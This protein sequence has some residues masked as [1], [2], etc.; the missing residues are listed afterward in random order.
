MD[1]RTRQFYR[2]APRENYSPFVEFARWLARTE[3]LAKSIVRSRESK[4]FSGG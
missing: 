4:V 2:T 1:G 3:Q